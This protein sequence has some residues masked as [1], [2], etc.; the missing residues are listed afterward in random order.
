MAS[1]LYPSFMMF[2]TNAA[3]LNLSVQQIEAY[4]STLDMFKQN[5]FDMYYKERLSGKEIGDALGIQAEKV[6]YHLNKIKDGLVHLSQLFANDVTLIVGRSGVG[7][8]TLEA[9]LCELYDLVPVRSYTTR[10]QRS[11]EDNTHRFIDIVDLDDYTDKVA[12][13]VINGHHYFATKSQLEESDLYVIDPNGLLELTQSLPDFT[14]NLI[15]IHPT[16]EEHKNRLKK[17][18]QE[19]IETKESQKARLQSEKEQFDQFEKQ[20]AQN[21]LPPNVNVLSLKQLVPTF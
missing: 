17:R 11:P 4:V 16:K 10:K 8:S 3:E 2:N 19:T 6:H 15:Y 1:H 7:K 12:T 9:R 14:F 20:L 5:L 21:D 18:R 13:T